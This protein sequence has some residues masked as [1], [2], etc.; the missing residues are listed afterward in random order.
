MGQPTPPLPAA[1]PAA[2][3]TV[4][5]AELLDEIRQLKTQVA[6][7]R[8]LK[9]Q[10]TQLQNE[11]SNLR[12]SGATS[13][14]RDFASVVATEAPPS[15]GPPTPAAPATRGETMT[16]HTID[17]GG[18]RNDTLTD[19]TPLQFRYRYLSEANGPIAGGTFLTISDPNEEFTL[20][21]QNQVTIDST[22]F[23]RANMPTTEQGW[24]IPFGRT[25]I[26]G[27]VT[28]NFGYQVTLQYFLG[29]INLLDMFA[30]YQWDK[31]RLRFGKGL[32]PVLYEYYAFSP[33]FEP[34]ITNSMSFQLAN[35]RPIGATFIYG[36]KYMQFWS[37]ITNNLTSG[38]YALDRNPELTG[39]V[40]L[41]PFKNTDGIFKHLGGG[42]GWSVGY[43]N[44]SLYNPAATTPNLM[45]ST[46]NS[47]WVTSSGV[48]FAVYNQNVRSVGE[49]TR[50]APHIFWY[51]RFSFLGEYIVHSR[52]LSDGTTTARSTQNALMLMG[53]YYL[54]GERDYGG[55]GIQGFSSVEPI[56]PFLFSR[57][58]W[59]IGAWQVAAQWSQFN[60]GRA[61]F[62][63]GFINSS[64]YT[65][66][67]EQLMV[68]VNW[69][70]VKNTR[71]SFDWVWTQF[72]NPIPF[73]G[74]TP[75]SGFN[76]FWFRYAMFF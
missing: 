44:Y 73:T 37:G 36:G 48:P 27:N 11:L 13:G 9:D 56:R 40:T 12:Q 6:E 8:Q 46:T 15:M 21:F 22:N 52:E 32:S 47:A 49:R 29:E 65:N 7:T 39:A 18:A 60:V 19:F 23:D 66:R 16:S 75:L 42:V 70:P 71:L 28:K 33:A 76:T 61:D 53:S 74:G 57:G 68:G 3:V 14:N 4:S 64:L 41:T 30:T 51:G 67:A 38:Y 5:N 17:T 31:I 20:K 58:Q 25:G 63:N 54:T 1:L 50:I 24:N 72:N 69:W 45:E 62:T 55:N 34:V 35:K 43:E 26:W 2:P 10:V 59:G